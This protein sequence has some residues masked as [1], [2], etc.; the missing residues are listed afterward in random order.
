MR[1]ILKIQIDH[2]FR[3][4]RLLKN[5]NFMQGGIKPKSDLIIMQEAQSSKENNS[6]EKRQRDRVT[7][8]EI[9]MK[10]IWTFT[11]LRIQF[12]YRCPASLVDI[13]AAQL[14][15]LIANRSMGLSSTL[16]R[17]MIRDSIQ[18]FVA[19]FCQIFRKI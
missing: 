19:E 16:S 15:N 1:G 13:A 7:K 17:D 6:E 4:C 5:A 18:N 2:W 14:V 9:I 12:H 11:L 3:S 8:L 10:N